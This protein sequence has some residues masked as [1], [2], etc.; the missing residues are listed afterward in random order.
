M[1]RPISRQPIPPSANLVFQGQL[2]DVLQWEQRLFNGTTVT[3]EKLRRPD[4]AY[5]IAVQHDNSLVLVEQEQPG[6]QKYVGLIGGRVESGETAEQA[7]RRELREETGMQAGKLVLWKSFQFLPK[8]D[9]AIYIFIARNC[10]MSASNSL[11]AGEKI[12]MVTLSLDE[13]FRAAATSLLGDV[14]V[15][16]TLLRVKDDMNEL[17]AFKNLLIHSI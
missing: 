1:K 4:T 17:Q 7:A 6:S 11:D 2:F 8:I 3:F 5:V 16:L 15:A 14:E 10:L 9:W 12:Q 13:V